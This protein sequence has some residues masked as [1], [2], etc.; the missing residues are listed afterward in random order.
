MAHDQAR[1]DKALAVR[2]AGGRAAGVARRLVKAARP[3]DLP[4][5]PRTLEDAVRWS[6]WAM[7]AVACGRIDARTGHE[8]GYLV[9]AFKAA[10]EKRDLL[11]E[12]DLLREELAAARKSRGPRAS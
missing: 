7:H 11:R 3:E 8:V 9:N 1:A 10:V 2:Q 5:A 4:P 6:S 12:I